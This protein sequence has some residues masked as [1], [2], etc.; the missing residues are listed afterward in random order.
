MSGDFILGIDTS[1]RWG[2]LGL[3]DQEGMV[4]S[5]TMRV[6]EGHSKGLTLRIEN[7]MKDAGVDPT[8]L[9]AIGV[10]NGP[11]SFTALRVGV[12]TAQGLGMGLGIPVVPLG[13][14]EV[15]AAGIPPFQ[16]KLLVLLP[17]RKNE[18]FAQVFALSN[19]GKWSPVDLINCMKLEELTIFRQNIE[20]VTG[21]ALDLYPEELA[22]L[23]GG[24][25]HWASYACRYGH[26]EMVAELARQALDNNQNAFQ[27]ENI[28]IQY[29]QSHGALTI[30]ERERG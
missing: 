24:S 12:A 18:V 25:N 21:P 23:L 29:L 17:A 2:S 22:V 16:G 10:V 6:R 9:S 14:L 1:S 11:G 28:T 26:G 30:A 3:T 7:H 8:Q 15:L 4:G 27:A 20:C 13:S 19:V 5:T